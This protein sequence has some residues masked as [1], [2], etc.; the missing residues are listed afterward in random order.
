MQS[1]DSHLLQDSRSSAE[2]SLRQIN[3]FAISLLQQQTLEDLL[4]SIVENVGSLLGYEDCVIYLREGDRLVQAASYASQDPDVRHHVRSFALRLGEGIVGTVAQTGSAK[5]VDD[6][7]QDPD[8][9]A[10]DF[11]GLSELA[12]PILFEDRV[13]GVL[14]SENRQV[15]AYSEADQAQMQFIAN[16]AASRIASAL[17]EGERRQLVDVLESKNAELERFTYTVSH[18]LKSPLVTIQGFL[19]LIEQDAAAGDTER[20]ERDIER[21]RKAARGMGELLN[22]LLALSRVGRQL[23]TSHEISVNKLVREAVAQ[24]SGQIRSRGVQL[25]IA[26]E[27]PRVFGD[28]QRLLTVWQNLINN[29]VKFMGDQSEP[30]IELGARRDGMEVVCYV[31]DNGAGI[32]ARFH[33]K[34]FDLFDRLDKK[35]EG[36][37]IGLAL[38]KRIV[39]LHG[40]RVWVE[41]EGEGSGS[42]FFFSCPGTNLKATD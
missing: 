12:V 16:I 19:N 35:I 5:I 17:A 7:R 23:S 3:W 41:S 22:D 37:G 20:L 31:R 25:E 21:I 11:V 38:V 9:V 33:E 4:W 1:S 34:I 36:T 15:G 13:I 26:A 32:D 10:S 30:K 39:E 8:Y 29:A 14:D 42:T 40:G 2:E 27:L 18:D 28:R 24:V 6:T